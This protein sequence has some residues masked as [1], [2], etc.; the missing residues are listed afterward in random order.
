MHSLSCIY[1]I[2]AYL[3]VRARTHADTHVSVYTRAFMRVGA[4]FVVPW[5]SRCRVEKPGEHSEMQQCEGEVVLRVA[6]AT[7]QLGG[8]AVQDS[9]MA[10]VAGHPEWSPNARYFR[11]PG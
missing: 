10:G 8:L 2:Q 5:G 11:Q 7:A 9:V 6:E 1:T 4:H 3:R